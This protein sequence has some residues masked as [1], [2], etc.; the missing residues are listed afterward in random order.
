LPASPSSGRQAPGC[1]RSEVLVEQE[2]VGVHLKQVFLEQQLVLAFCDVVR[3]TAMEQ[4]QQQLQ[5]SGRQLTLRGVD[6][7]LQLLLAIDGL[8]ST[9][10]PSACS[11]GDSHPATSP[12]EAQTG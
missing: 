2:S 7:P 6:G 5:A 12:P 8:F 4:A 9:L 1:R 10:K 3:A 11:D